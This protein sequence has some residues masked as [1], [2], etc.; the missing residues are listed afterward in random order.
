EEAVENPTAEQ[1]A[2][3]WSEAAANEASFNPGALAERVGR[4]DG[5]RFVT[6]DGDG[7][8]SL[9]IVAPSRFSAR[10]IVAVKTVPGEG[11]PDMLTWALLSTASSESLGK[12]TLE[13]NFENNVIPAGRNID[14]FI[15][16]RDQSGAIVTSYEGPS[17]FSIEATQP[18]ESWAGLPSTGFKPEIT[19]VFV[20]GRCPIPGGPFNFANAQTIDVSIKGIKPSLSK[21]ETKIEVE[22]GKTP[23]QVI[24]TDRPGG[25]SANST[26]V[27]NV[28][29][30]A[31][32]SVDLSSAFIDEGGNYLGDAD[33]THWISSDSSFQQFLPID[34]R[35]GFALKPTKSGLFELKLS[36]A[37][38]RNGFA[39]PVEVKAGNLAAWKIETQHNGVEVA[40]SCFRV[41]VTA[42]DAAG[43]TV[44]T[45][46]GQIVGELKI[47]GTTET[48]PAVN[49]I[50]H[51]ERLGLRLTNEVEAKINFQFG[52][53]QANEQACL[54][55]ATNVSPKITFF[56]NGLQNEVPVS[57]LKGVPSAL[58]ISELNTGELLDN[59]LQLENDTNLC[60]TPRNPENLGNPC[61]KF[62]ADTMLPSGA[63]SAPATPVAPDDLWRV[64]A[65]VTL[66]V[67]ATDVA[68]NFIEKTKARWIATGPLGELN[69][70]GQ[71][72]F[73]LLNSF[74]PLQ[75]IVTTFAGKG[76]IQVE[77][78][79][80]ATIDISPQRFAYEIVH[81][82]PQSAVVETVTANRQIATV[83]FRIKATIF[84]K[85][86][87]AATDFKGT[88]PATVNLTRAPESP[89]G[90]TAAV[91]TF[92]WNMDFS[93]GGGALI[94]STGDSLRLPC[95]CNPDVQPAAGLGC[96]DNSATAS[97]LG[98]EIITLE[99]LKDSSGAILRDLS[100]NPIV[101]ENK[102]TYKCP[103]VQLSMSGLGTFLSDPLRVDPGVLHRIAWRTGASGG[104]DDIA[105]KFPNSET[106]PLEQEI[107]R[108]LNLFV[109]GYDALGNY[110]G[111]VTSNLT[112][113]WLTPGI[114]RLPTFIPRTASPSIISQDTGEGFITAASFLPSGFNVASPK[115]RF[116]STQAVRYRIETNHTDPSTLLTTEVAGEPFNIIIK[117]IDPL[118]NVDPNFSGTR[119]FTFVSVSDP[120]WSLYQPVL[121]EGANIGCAFVS[122]V[123]LLSPSVVGKTDWVIMNSLRPSIINMTETT[124]PADLAGKNR[125]EG[126][127]A[128]TIFITESPADSVVLAD[129]PGGPKPPS[130]LEA[131]RVRLFGASE[132]IQITTDD[133]LEFYAAL[134]DKGGNY[135]AELLSESLQGNATF[136]TPFITATSETI[137]G[138]TAKKIR[139][140]PKK[141]TPRAAGAQPDPADFSIGS[142]NAAITPVSFKVAVHHGIPA[143]IDVKLLKEFPAG[144]WTQ[145]A[146]FLVAGECYAIAPTVMDAAN[147]SVD[148][149][150]GIAITEIGA[151]NFSVSNT[152]RNFSGG[153]YRR[154][155]F[156]PHVFN[157]AVLN[158]G[159][160]SIVVG[161]EFDGTIPNFVETNFGLVS[162]GGSTQFSVLSNSGGLESDEELFFC[163]SDAENGAARHLEP[164]IVLEIL[165]GLS[166][167]TKADVLTLVPKITGSS[168][169][170]AV[171]KGPPAAIALFAKIVAANG[172]ETIGPPVCGYN[173]DSVA[174]MTLTALG[175]VA[176][177]RRFEEL[178]MFGTD[179]PSCVALNADQSGLNVVAKITDAA[180]N[181]L[182]QAANGSWQF[183]SFAGGNDTGMSAAT[184]Q[185]TSDTFRDTLKRAGQFV[186]EFTDT[187]TQLKVNHVVQVKA[188]RAHRFELT[189]PVSVAATEAFEAK[190]NF[191]DN[192]NNH[193]C[194]G[195]KVNGVSDGFQ[196]D[197]L[198]GEDN[199]TANFKFEWIS[200]PLPTL[201]KFP[202]TGV[203]LLGGNG[204][205]FE[206]V[207]SCEG[208]LFAKTN[209][210]QIPKTGNYVLRAEASSLLTAAGAPMPAA[211]TRKTAKINVVPGAIEESRAEFV[212]AVNGNFKIPTS[213]TTE[214]SNST[215]AAGT[216]PRQLVSYNMTHDL[217]GAPAGAGTAV[218]VYLAGYDRE[219]NFSGLLPSTIGLVSATELESLPSSDS[220]FTSTPCSSAANFGRTLCNLSL[221]YDL[222]DKDKMHIIGGVRAG[223]A[224]I[225]ITPAD[226][227]E[228]P[229]TLPEMT[230]VAGSARQ[231][232]PTQVDLSG[233]RK[234]MSGETLVDSKIAFKLRMTDS[235]FN[236]IFS[237]DD[238][239]N[240]GFRFRE[241]EVF[242]F[243][244]DQTIEGVVN[245]KPADGLRDFN[246]GISTETF[247]IELYVAGNYFLYLFSGSNF[248]LDGIMTLG[249]DD[250]VRPD[251]FDHYGT[252]TAR[253][254]STLGR[255]IHDDYFPHRDLPAERT[256]S[257]LIQKRDKFGNL[258][259]D[260]A[261]VPVNLSIVRSNGVSVGSCSLQ[262]ATTTNVA[263]SG[264]EVL[265]EG[266]RYPQSGSFK[267]IASDSSGKTTPLSAARTIRMI[268]S[269]DT[270][271]DFE[272]RRLNGGASNI[273]VNAGSAVG[274]VI[275]GRDA[276]GESLIGFDETLTGLTYSWTG[277]SSALDAENTIPNL[278][279][280]LNFTAGQSSATAVFFRAEVIAAN[281]LTVTTVGD[282][283]TFTG[284]YA[285]SITVN[286]GS[287][288]EYVLKTCIPGG[289]CDQTP[290]NRAADSGPGGRFSINISAF[291]EWKNQRAGEAGLRLAVNKLSGVVDQTSDVLS[292]TGVAAHT[293]LETTSINMTLNALTFT[294]SD[295][296]YPVG[297]NVEFTL[298]NSAIGVANKPTINFSYTADS[299]HRYKLAFSQNIITAGNNNI[300][301]T[302]SALD[303][304]ENVIPTLDGILNAR[305]FTLEGPLFSP[306]GNSPTIFN[307][308]G[309][310]ARNALV[311]AAWNNFANGVATGTLSLFR[312]QIFQVGGFLLTD[313][314]GLV[315]AN[316]ELIRVDE[317]A[318][319]DIRIPAGGGAL[320]NQT[321]GVSFNIEALTLD[322]FGNPTDVSC[323][324]GLTIGNG[325][326]SPGGHG[327]TATP[328]FVP[329]AT[330]LQKGSYR[331]SGIQLF[332]AGTTSLTFNACGSTKPDLSFF[333][334]TAPVNR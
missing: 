120:S 175:S 10:I 292:A 147:Q 250:F 50:A 191:F 324:A 148:T 211:S 4:I 82:A 197:L 2:K 224:V 285:G 115:I 62:S 21:Y 167:K 202:A 194:T 269:F 208:G 297:H 46:E 23:A 249:N 86:K 185:A 42:I 31:G 53:G 88:I 95:A 229:I 260:G 170:F 230:V 15:V 111:E 223:S 179:T 35:N 75:T 104:G 182:P 66:Y 225:R 300:T 294:L 108:P 173:G 319:Q 30:D 262:G 247:E 203:S 135:K 102:T 280:E 281:S 112:W 328:A 34:T 279:D 38:A 17:S 244:P 259:S 302:A 28:T 128:T 100:N 321:A 54:Y 240:L 270:L 248:L 215:T 51:F 205:F 186:I 110:R 44:P 317:A 127:F 107:F 43:N 158:T 209:L 237:Q 72:K 79:K 14:F 180:G 171:Q 137:A 299:I 90:A 188:G 69:S 187:T 155:K 216:F 251:P 126:T 257:T 200:S 218:A 178:W 6:T 11:A 98:Y 57:V 323:A 118:G 221:H 220:E 176:A 36:S 236:T 113:T 235:N 80:T 27:R 192:N 81:G 144:Q 295:L 201:A 5:S 56:A 94:S 47:A 217:S 242:S 304:A 37:S 293:S 32:Q 193:I 246:A 234:N 61:I 101:D 288:F 314:V 29:L 1:V 139:F 64:Q 3:L 233:Q 174:R 311:P 89:D 305:T 103:Q 149:L 125:L 117:A 274:L 114:V 322:P 287:I 85:W 26:P 210:L 261:N 68:G 59:A 333:V 331:F 271:K 326:T 276:C 109:A 277:A 160:N 153:F 177:A 298:A 256:F 132:I 315:G 39:L 222:P 131:A 161:P 164:Q 41:T 265:I 320:P 133:S 275:R 24:A 7:K 22:K 252:I 154:S 65:P 124:L 45:V 254:V 238:P 214:L 228:P 83:P 243:P 77:A 84:D 289:S 310:V 181:I 325:L 198:F 183:I 159:R 76:I 13:S 12:I 63:T 307:A 52:T 232:V 227:D 313:N 204:T 219:E 199:N 129:R 116:K 78:E 296:Y 334:N 60:V 97:P 33:N 91:S 255:I 267:L 312:A 169:K 207:F 327:G 142:S 8:V 123:C 151:K 184:F 130:P 96:R 278:P 231:L 146:N 145:T 166:F 212:P 264:A 258:V 165:T 332:K 73:A 105:V 136:V 245:V 9:K 291:D 48:P 266:L 18:A 141:K 282:G 162:N 303:R 74:L 306:S 119:K 329:A 49:D 284:H 134:V 286:P 67:S 290:K 140:A 93:A 55:D 268:S 316:A 122:G 106:T 241:G 157:Q 195:F 283:T 206:S 20:A 263:I 226:V 92:S 87:N 99:H 58:R 172:T 273:S 121:P 253:E 16:L 308:A 152:L 318:A 189:A 272:V 330:K 25:P 143:K 40:G 168:Q 309:D 213:S 70:S 19:C 71:S 150:D 156:P 301:V 190:M 163:Q 239:V 196:T 138:I